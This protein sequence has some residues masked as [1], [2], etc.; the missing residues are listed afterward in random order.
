M[1]L[2]LILILPSIEE[3]QL[4]KKVLE[5]KSQIGHMNMEIT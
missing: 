4:K 2:S 1:L 5:H 3:F